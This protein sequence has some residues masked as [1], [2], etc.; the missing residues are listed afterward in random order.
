MAAGLV[1]SAPRLIPADEPV[2]YALLSAANDAPES[3]RTVLLRAVFLRRR[4]SE[5]PPEGLS[6]RKVF[7]PLDRAGLKRHDP[8]MERLLAKLWGMAE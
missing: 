1:A 6:S 8:A 3:V 7:F 2:A 5:L 4:V